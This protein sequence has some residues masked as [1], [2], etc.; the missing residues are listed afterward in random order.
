MY[1]SRSKIPH[2]SSFMNK[3]SLNIPDMDGS[4]SKSS[5]DVMACHR[6]EIGK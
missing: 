3:T 4:I 6:M 2:K 5:E 1:T